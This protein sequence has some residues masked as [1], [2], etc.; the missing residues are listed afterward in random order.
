MLCI[1]QIS[2]GEHGHLMVELEMRVADRS[3]LGERAVHGDHSGSERMQEC[4]GSAS[5]AVQLAKS[6]K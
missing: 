5:R 2:E 6:R 3:V 4:D 1:Q